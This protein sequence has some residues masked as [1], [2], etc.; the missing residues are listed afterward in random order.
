MAEPITLNEKLKK[1]VSTLTSQTKSIETIKKEKEQPK[2][3][4]VT[5]VKVK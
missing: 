4:L 2:P 5:N 3:V 1:V